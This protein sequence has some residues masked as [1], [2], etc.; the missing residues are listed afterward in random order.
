[1]VQQNLSLD[2]QVTESEQLSDNT[3]TDASKEMIDTSSSKSADRFPELVRLCAIVLRNTLLGGNVISLRFLSS[4]RLMAHYVAECLFLSRLLYRGNGLPQVHVWQGLGIADQREI[5]LTVSL[6][7]AQEWLRSVPSFG[8]DLL[9]LCLLAKIAGSRVIF[10]I[11]TLHGSSA[12]HFALCSPNAEIYTLDL[13]SS[14]RPS[15]RTTTMDEAHIGDHRT[16]KSYYFSG[17]AEEKQIRPLF[18]DS[19]T[20]DFSPFFGRVDLFFVDGSHSYEYVRNDTE[21]ALQCVR[22]GG[23]IAWHDYG[24][25]GVNGVTQWLHEFRDAGNKV[26]RVPGGSLAYMRVTP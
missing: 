15:L 19:G 14:A 23:I 8:I 1:M 13:P 22:P 2:R 11:G 10:E 4:P 20:F 7:A 12:L 9:N 5:D 17:R 21:K 26:F 25:A 24:R 6:D 3:K 18:G 16:A